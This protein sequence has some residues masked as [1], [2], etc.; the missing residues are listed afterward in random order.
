MYISFYT[1]RGWNR[2]V[3]PDRVVQWSTPWVVFLWC[4]MHK[5]FSCFWTFPFPVYDNFIPLPLCSSRS[6]KYINY[7]KGTYIIVSNLCLFTCPPSHRRSWNPYPQRHIS[8]K[9]FCQIHS[10]VSGVHFSNNIS[11][12][13]VRV[14]IKKTKHDTT[15]KIS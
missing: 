14:S 1:T 5:S 10:P 7:D 8:A 11:I 6:H 12:P 15:F 9:G 2:Q 4:P 3:F 13:Q